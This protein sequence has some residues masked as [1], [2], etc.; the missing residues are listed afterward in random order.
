[1]RK[2]EPC[3]GH[4]SA[5]VAATAHTNVAAVCAGVVVLTTSSIEAGLLW[6]TAVVAADSGWRTRACGVGWV[7]AQHSD[8]RPIL[9]ATKGDHVLTD[10]SSDDLTALR[11]GVGEDVL[12]KI[13][14]ELV[15]GNVD[16]RHARA[17]RTSLAHDIE[18]AVKEVGAADLQ[19]LLNNFGGKLVHAVLC[20]ET[21]DV[22]DSTVAVRKSTVLADVLDAPVAELAVSDDINT[23]KDLADTRTFVLIETVL[24]D[25]LDDKTASLT[26]R[27]LVPHPAKSL[28]DVSHDLRRRTTPTE[29]EKL[30]PNM[31]CV[32]VDDSLGDA[33]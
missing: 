6:V 18:V 10:V 27:D 9:G 20:G 28:V 3:H 23:G 29:L 24:E 15:T 30:L 4:D 26:Q 31:A 13:V 2:I 22:V 17:V 11:I 5:V 1:M 14:A 25:V 32:A 33:T 12:N 8:T 19:T 16:E 21:Q 7:A